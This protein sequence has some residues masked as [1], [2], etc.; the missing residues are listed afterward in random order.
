M[1]IAETK[2]SIIE[3]LQRQ[4]LELQG[5]RDT[6]TS[7]VK[8]LGE[9]EKAFPN[10]TFPTGVIHEFT[11]NEYGGY[12]ATHGFI[13]ALLG[14]LMAQGGP[15]LW[16]SR[17]RRAAPGGLAAFGI[18]P[19][20]V[21]F[22]DL[23]RDK[24]LLWTIEEALKCPGLSAVVGEVG[25]LDFNASRR[26]QLAVEESRVTGFI[27]CCRPAYLQQTTSVAR[28][29][30]AP[31]PSWLPDGMPGIGHPCW[32]VELLK[33]RSGKPGTWDIQYAAGQLR[34]LDRQSVT[35]ATYLEN[36]G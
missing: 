4:I 17:N 32:R 11:S 8:G 10:G 16:V 28:W 12:V 23:D 29:R 5:I 22:I 27:H 2:K 20:R 21:I 7:K 18:P 13:A 15:C 36:A 1:E 3:K 30:I 35:A 9:V 24:D 26:L 14:K 19:E 31:L 6:G 33:V 25:N 34:H